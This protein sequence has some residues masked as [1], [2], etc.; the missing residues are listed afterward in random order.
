MKNIKAIIFDWGRTIY[1]KDN[2]RL[3][4]ET[5]DV[6]DYC[7]K[8]YKLAI[9]SLA[10]DGNL[11]GRFQKL[12]KYDIRKHFKLSLFH[13]SDKDSLFRNAVGNLNLNTDQVLVIDDRIRRLEWPIKNG[14][15]T[16]WIQKGKFENELPD[17]TT[18]FPT[19]K[20]KSLKEIINYI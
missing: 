1:D 2:E 18:G 9:V 11:E 12:D 14:C 13:F 17:E 5:K 8:K 20:V 3:F 10:V 15:K 7:V 19:L 16:V 6:L 4:P